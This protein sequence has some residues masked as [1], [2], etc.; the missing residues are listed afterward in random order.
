M[1]TYQGGCHCG[2]VRFEIESDLTKA[3]EC[4]CTICTRKGALHHRVPPDQFKLLSGQDSLSL[5]QSGSKIAK[6]WF[7]RACGIHPFSNPRAAPEMYSVN[8]R[9]LDDYWAEVP[10]IEVRLFDGR[11]WEDAIKTFKF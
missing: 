8:I 9:C 7:C 4:N 11:N 5:Y 2:Q 10:N 3:T 6:H 1:K